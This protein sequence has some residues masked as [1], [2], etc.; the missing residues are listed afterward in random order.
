MPDISGRMGFARWALALILATSLIPATAL[1]QVSPK[2]EAK[3]EAEA[4]AA[5]AQPAPKDLAIPL[6]EISQRAEQTT[7]TLSAAINVLP[8]DER[9]AKIAEQIPKIEKSLSKRRSELDRELA[10]GQ[11]RARLEG[12]R[13]DWNQ[14]LTQLN[15]WRDTLDPLIRKI[16][17]ALGSLSK[18]KEIWELTR[19]QAEGADSPDRIVNRIRITL[20]EIDKAIATVSASRSSL[21]TLQDQVVQ[22][23]LVATAAVERIE[24][25][26]REGRSGLFERN[27]PPLWADLRKIRPGEHAEEIRASIRRD[28]ENLREFAAA[29]GSQFL[30]DLLIFIVAIRYASAVK[31][32]LVNPVEGIPPIGSS[33][34]LFER[35]VSIAILTTVLLARL[36]HGTPPIAF[37]TIIS[38]VLIVPLVR[39]VPLLL[40]KNIR[41]VVWVVA[42]LVAISRTRLMMNQS[43]LAFEFLFGLES[44]SLMAM[45]LWLMRPS[46]LR[47]I[48]P[49]SNLPPLLGTGMRATLLLLLVSI[50]SGALGFRSFA[51]LIGAATTSSVYAALILYA[52]TGAFKVG[53]EASFHTRPAQNMSFVRRRRN[54]VLDIT[55]RYAAVV[56]GIYWAYLTL[57]W[58]EIFEP[59]SAL[60]RMILAAHLNVGEIQISFGDVIAFILTVV[61]AFMLSRLIRFFL[62]EEAFPRM[63]L[64][65][66]VGNAVSTLLHYIVLLLGFIF[67]LSAAG[68]DFTRV[69]LFAG[70]FSVGIGFGL[71]TVVNNFV[72]GLILLFERPIQIGDMVEVGGLFGEVRRI[73]ARSSTVRTFDGAEVIVP[74]SNLITDP[75]TNWTLSDRRRRLEL[76]VGVAYG[77]D[78]EV[79]LKLLKGVAAA[80]ESV[81]DSP[82]PEALFLEFGDSALKFRLRV[83]I[84][85]FEEGFSIRS[86]LTV[87]INAALRDAG[88]TIPF[89]Q[90]DL[91][92][93]SVESDVIRSL[94]GQNR[95]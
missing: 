53:V 34:E 39:L 44:L 81:L 91:H 18:E 12:Y 26:Q 15:D 62:E 90:R 72:S 51:S 28:L 82:E 2:P 85:R 33:G 48:P 87:A 93:R 68:M 11:H 80:H 42:G 7:R 9:T 24:A 74:N 16:E 61:V 36:V 43:P 17:S 66:G 46:M 10:S 79:V 52:A 75:V 54:V 67:A 60:V 29:S 57:R 45:L 55:G 40:P 4:K 27:A 13:A 21:L 3:A 41:W 5:G 6:V 32:R 49:G 56:A 59:A 63:R 38:L 83:W 76:E 78:P 23:D 95:E 25:A 84:P 1:A 50:L 22:Q 86:Q 64:R 37:T 92:V 14:T 69:A 47:E 31:R 35:P 70:A 58:F 73:G 71:Q 88:I 20:S 30:L 19:Q 94:D 77:T 8:T 65:R 89:P